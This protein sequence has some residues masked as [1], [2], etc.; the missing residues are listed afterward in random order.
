M[1]SESSTNNLDGTDKISLHN[2]ASNSNDE[3]SVKESCETESKKKEEEEDEDED[4][5]VNDDESE[6]DE[7]LDN[8]GLSSTVNLKASVLQRNSRNAKKES[9]NLLDN[10]PRS[11]LLIQGGDVHGLFNFLLN[12]KICF[13]SSGPMQ[14]VPP[15]LIAPTTF[16]GA[17]MQKLKVEKN[18][19]KNL[20]STGESLTQY[21]L[22]FT[23]PIMPYHLHR[24]SSLFVHTQKDEFE[25][26]LNVYQQS[27]AFNSIKL[28][29]ETPDGSSC[30][31]SNSNSAH[32]SSMLNVSRLLDRSEKISMQRLVAINGKSDSFKTITHKD[33]KFFCEESSTLN[34]K[35]S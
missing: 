25:V 30:E 34:A 12:D 1:N 8:I 29:S 31:D 13:A 5:D 10:R 17:T 9:M 19:K 20:T 3:P 27:E 24:L 18:L 28:G 7:W 21:T 11:T 32:Q 35:R 2:E 16:I 4:L 14:G 23:G 22:D 33:G 6:A 26:I 15:T